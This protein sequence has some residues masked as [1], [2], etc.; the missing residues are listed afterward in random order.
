MV[1]VVEDRL[2]MLKRM[3]ARLG[4]EIDCCR[5]DLVVVFVDDAPAMRVGV[6][7]RLMRLRRGVRSVAGRGDEPIPFACDRLDLAG[8]AALFAT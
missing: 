8:P 2:S 6:R 7:A 4:E 1:S 5:D 3:R